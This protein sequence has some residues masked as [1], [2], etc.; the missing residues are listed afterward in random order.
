MS[1]TRR[2]RVVLRRRPDGAPQP[3]D[4]AVEE[5]TLPEPGPGEVVVAACYVSIDPYVRTMIDAANPYGA[6]LPLGRTIAGDLAGEVLASNGG[7][8]EAGAWVAGRLGWTSHAT[9]DGVGLRR[10]DAGLGP[11]PLHLALYGSSGLTA[12]F[13]MAEIGRPQAGETVLVSGAAGAVGQVA[14]QLARV[15]GARVVGIAGGPAKGRHLVERLG[16]D[17]AIDHR[18]GT[19]PGD[20]DR[21]CPD[22][23]HVYFDNVGGPITDAVMARLAL[24]A[25]VVICGESSQY[26]AVGREYNPR[27]LGPL[28][29]K[30][31][32]MTGFLVSDFA[33]R[34]DLARAELARL[35]R[36]GRL[37]VDIDV[38]D[39]LENAPAAFV[40]ML[41]GDN[42][43]KR[44][45]R[46]T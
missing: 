19:L 7:P 39:G 23:V 2:R 38:V 44:L 13:G 8:F 25:R 42:I 17:G 5:D 1:G 21:L 18:A 24:H 37:I 12:Y 32:T 35:H 28:M 22:G 14:G 34:Y 33:Q 10:L 11:L 41:R 26:D 40:G 16:F 20:L 3:D 46:V 30:R 4:F 6:P 29:D 45:V 27:I 9:S 36:S 31:A 43:G 15:A